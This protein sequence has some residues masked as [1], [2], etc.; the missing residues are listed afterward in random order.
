MHSISSDEISDA[1][2]KL[3][4]SG[5]PP[6]GWN[7]EE[8]VSV[9]IQARVAPTKQDTFRKSFDLLM[10]SKVGVPIKGVTF[11]EN[12]ETKRSCGSPKIQFSRAVDLSVDFSSASAFL[13][14]VLRLFTEINYCFDRNATACGLAKKNE[15]VEYFYISENGFLVWTLNLMYKIINRMPAPYQPL[16]VLKIYPR[17]QA[18]P[19]PSPPA[20]PVSKKRKAPAAA[21]SAAASCPPPSPSSS[22]EPSPPRSPGAAAGSK[23]GKAPSAAG[24]PPPSPPPPRSKLHFRDAAAAKL[25]VA[26][27]RNGTATIR[28]EGCDAV[29]HSAEKRI[30]TSNLLDHFSSKGDFA[31]FDTERVCAIESSGEKKVVKVDLMVARRVDPFR[32]EVDV[33]ESK[34]KDSEQLLS[35]AVGELYSRQFVLSK[36]GLHLLR[37]ELQI[38]P[39]ILVGLRFAA[40]FG[41][42]PRQ[43]SVEFLRGHGFVVYY[44][45]DDGSVVEA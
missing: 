22:P 12:V 30:V 9:M 10:G 42:K 37:E 20:A 17:E 6:G 5:E 4:P 39:E 32:V 44:I 19:E 8:F 11:Q 2:Q 23:K 24:F 14:L 35:V 36:R 3:Y 21:S 25:E 31:G 43:V 1:V 38:G 40:A 27:M 15:G 29:D 41:S 13:D 45:A 28:R 7:K 34:V 18:P 16:K 26:A 33:V